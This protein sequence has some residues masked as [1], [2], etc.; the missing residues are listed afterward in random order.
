MLVQELYGPT[1]WLVYLL[2]FVIPPN[3]VGPGPTFCQQKPD[4]MYVQPSFCPKQGHILKLVCQWFYRKDSPT[5]RL[6]GSF[7][8]CVFELTRSRA[9]QLCFFQGLFELWLYFIFISTHSTT[10]LLNSTFFMNLFCY[11]FNKLSSGMT[12]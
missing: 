1:F 6:Y 9:V 5:H 7:C 2:S 4:K 11:Y 12:G 8:I 3:W 10:L